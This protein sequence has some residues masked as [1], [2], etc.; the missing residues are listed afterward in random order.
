MQK[1]RETTRKLKG[2]IPF[3]FFHS[4]EAGYFAAKCPH[5]NDAITKG[6]KG[7]RKFNK[8][9]KK[10]WFKKSFFSK[11]DSSSSDEDS[12]NEEEINRRVLF[13]AKHNKQEASNEEGDEEEE[14]TKVEF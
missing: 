1:I 3:I 10:K 9:G 4:G 2:K 11:E 6:K 13:M 12:D 8:Q 14:M 7:L 5:K